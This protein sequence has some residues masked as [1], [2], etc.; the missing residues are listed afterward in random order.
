MAPKRICKVGIVSTAHIR[1]INALHNAVKEASGKGMVCCT[2]ALPRGEYGSV[3]FQTM[4]IETCD[5]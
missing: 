1:K 4:Q 2:L 3:T 5:I